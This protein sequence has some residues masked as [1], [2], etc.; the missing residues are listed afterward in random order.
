MPRP[1]AKTL[2]SEGVAH[3]RRGA[4]AEAATLYQQALALDP[5]EPDALHLLGLL[6]GQSGQ[7][8]AGIGLI[9]RALQHRSDA[10]EYHG[11]LASLLQTGGRIDEAVSAARRACELAPRQPALAV[12]LGNILLTAGDVDAAESALER[13]I[14]VDPTLAEAHLGLGNVRSKRGDVPG[15]EA[16]W[17]RA[18][19]LRPNLA[20]AQANLARSRQSAGDLTEAITH[21]RQAIALRPADAALLNDLGT[22]LHDNH[23]YLDAA[24]THQAALLLDPDSVRTLSNLGAALH[25][26]RRYAEAEQVHRRAVALEPDNAVALTHLG[27]ALASQGRDAAAIE[28]HRQALAIDPDHA[29]ARWN[30]ST[31][32]LG[33]GEMKEGWRCYEARWQTILQKAARDYPVPLWEGEPIRG[34]RILLW[35]EQGIG[36]EIMFLSCLPD[37]L[38][39]GATVILAATPKL[40][41]L[42]VRSFPAVEVWEDWRLSDAGALGLDFHLPIGSLPRWLRPTLEHFPSHTG[43]LVPDPTRSAQWGSRLAALGPAPRVGISWRSR[44]MTN[45]RLAFYSSLADWGPILTTP[46][47]SFINL[48]Y[49]RCGPELEAAESA[50]GVPI[51][52]FEDLDLFDDLDGAAALTAGL[53]LVIA[54]DNSVGELAAALGRPV[55]RLDSGADWSAFGTGAR[56]WQPSMRLFQRRPGQNWAPLI[57][58]VGAALAEWREAAHHPKPGVLK[59]LSAEPMV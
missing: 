15:A 48:Q 40:R 20:E 45:D 38:D 16:S 57:A 10:A 8:E 13:A 50:H 43:Y 3:H 6:L 32:L 19:E 46:G 25:Q 18:I 24:K 30:I 41:P 49:D 11:N 35:R 29:A 34:K 22:A 17:R 5:E 12:N 37:L 2:L 52:R 31:L 53:D 58:E 56:P 59:Y 54:P 28:C 47:L 23:E 4:L 39:L 42:L 36:D 33:R 44:L 14:S 9:E 7:T 1:T 21:Y 27:A 51:H 55:W 26:L